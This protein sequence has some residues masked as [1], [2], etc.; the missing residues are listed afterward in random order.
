MECHWQ[1]ILCESSA[2]LRDRCRYKNVNDFYNSNNCIDAILESV[3]MLSS[4]VTWVVKIWGKKERV[5]R[6]CSQ[7]LERIISIYKS[8]SLLMHVRVATVP[9]LSIKISPEYSAALCYFRI[10]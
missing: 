5:D 4:R 10:T 7:W 3:A 8:F 1:F 9:C 2:S 6:L